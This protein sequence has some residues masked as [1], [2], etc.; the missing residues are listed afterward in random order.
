M[1]V[2]LPAFVFEKVE[3]D[4]DEYDDDNDRNDNDE[5]LAALD[6]NTDNTDN[7]LEARPFM[8]LQ[9]IT[10]GP[11][12]W[13][14]AKDAPIE[15]ETRDT[16][17]QPTVVVLHHKRESVTILFC[18]SS[19]LIESATPGRLHFQ[20]MLRTT[21]ERWIEAPSFEKPWKMM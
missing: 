18:V 5:G 8:N 21:L 2:R 11:T 15:T 13:E 12:P 3:D 4:T 16:A 6:D 7:T 14:N 10:W 17:T 19:T 9:G 1:T 20:H